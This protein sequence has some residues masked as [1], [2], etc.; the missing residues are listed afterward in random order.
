MSQLSRRVEKRNEGVDLSKSYSLQEA[1]ALVKERANAK[2]DE[3]MDFVLHC[4]IDP[5]KSDQNVRG[6]VS[7][8]SGTGKAVRVAVFAQ[9]EHAEQARQAGADRVGDMDLIQDVQDG[10]IDFD[11]CIATPPMMAHLSKLGKILGPRNLM[12]NPKLGT[13]T[14]DV[15]AAVEK[16]KKGQ[17]SVRSDKKGLVHG[18]FG[19]AS[20]SVDDLV[21][22]FK[23]IYEAVSDMKPS[24][25]K[26]DM[27]RKASIS[28][29][30]GFGLQIDLSQGLS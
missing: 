1:L 24:S 29:T 18:A 14:M 20:F 13:V 9:G 26:S 16:A 8:P 21:A 25:L 30:M 28:S 10:K 5:N 4:A 6:M 11:L 15:G 2:F 7:L 19:R 27:V 12:P 23:A 3:T 22:N 17:I